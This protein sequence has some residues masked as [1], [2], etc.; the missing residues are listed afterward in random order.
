MG[1]LTS[2]FI[3]RDPFESMVIPSKVHTRDPVS[4]ILTRK[5]FCV[6]SARLRIWYGH[7]PVMYCQ[8]DAC[9]I[10]IFK[11]Q[12]IRYFS[13]VSNVIRKNFC[14]QKIWLRISL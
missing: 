3:Q 2:L 1:I 11:Y 6:V 4:W 14:F 9:G 8:S 12:I 10:M 7:V 5:P 13:N